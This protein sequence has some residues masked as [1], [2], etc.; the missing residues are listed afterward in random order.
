[1]YGVQFGEFV[2][3]YRGKGLKTP[4]LKLLNRSKMTEYLYV[5]A[6]KTSVSKLSTRKL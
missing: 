2:S 6:I 3:G 5:P 4:L 1:M